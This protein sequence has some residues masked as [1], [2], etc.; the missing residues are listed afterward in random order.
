LGP[1]RI[2]NV[3]EQL[4]NFGGKTIHTAEWDSSVD[5]TDKVVAVVGSGER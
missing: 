4:R 2:P 5:V 3:P 1:L